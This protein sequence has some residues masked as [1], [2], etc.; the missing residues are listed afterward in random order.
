MEGVNV[1]F[2]AWMAA[3]DMSL[4]EM[5]QGAGGEGGALGD[6]LGGQFGPE[7]D[8]MLEQV[9]VLFAPAEE[10]LTRCGIE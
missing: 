1:Q 5:L 6:T 2:A 9:G 8:Q 10:W 3:E 7:F 4:D